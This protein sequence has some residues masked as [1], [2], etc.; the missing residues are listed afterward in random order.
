MGRKTRKMNTKQKKR[1]ATSRIYWKGAGPAVV[2]RACCLRS[3]L[4]CC[5]RSPCDRP[6]TRRSS[7]L[8]PSDAS[9]TG[10]GVDVVVVDEDEDDASDTDSVDTFFFFCRCPGNQTSRHE[11]AI[12]NQFGFRNEK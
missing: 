4:I 10:G 11:S 8:T 12:E 9:D 2:A 1:K 7:Q 6:S 5:S 3:A